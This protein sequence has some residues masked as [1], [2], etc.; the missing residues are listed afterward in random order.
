MK[1]L[2]SQSKL[3]GR[4]L[5]SFHTT[6]VARS[7]PRGPEVHMAYHGGHVPQRKIMKQR[8]K[9]SKLSVHGAKNQNMRCVE[10]KFKKCF[11]TA[12]G[13]QKYKKSTTVATGHAASTLTLLGLGNLETEAGKY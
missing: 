13:F 2:R 1:D 9:K 8:E 10:Q 5:D 6:R 3:V 12:F 7:Q 4:L 11:K